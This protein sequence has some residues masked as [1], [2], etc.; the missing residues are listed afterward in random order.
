MAAELT[1]TQTKVA[2][3]PDQLRPLTEL[4]TLVLD[5]LQF[6]QVLAVTDAAVANVRAG[7]GSSAYTDFDDR[8]VWI[9]DQRTR[10]MMRL[11]RWDAA[12]E[13]WA[14]A[15]RRPEQG[16]LNVSQMLNLGEYYVNRKQPAKAREMIAELG[17]MSDYG[18]M[19]L[20]LIQLKVAIEQH[21]KTAAASHLAYMRASD[22]C[23]R[24]LATG[25]AHQRGSRRRRRPAGTA[26]AE[27]GIAQ[28]RTCRHAGLREGVHAARRGR[29]DQALERGD[30]T[31]QRAKGTG[32][33]R[34][35]RTFQP[36]AGPDLR[37]NGS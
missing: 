4:Q 22:G 21:D 17:N 34:P 25:T 36:R 37:A 20:E 27:R 13:Q 14:A 28:Q 7:K 18:R 2:A 33:R 8:Y 16:G 30:R 35:D 11:G 12:T 10:A 9:L 3:H 23:D 6:D 15:T 32:A 29:V 1:A 5:T 24:H 31:T 26:S 19:T